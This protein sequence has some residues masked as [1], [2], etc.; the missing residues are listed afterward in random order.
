MVS[1]GSAFTKQLGTSVR[2]DKGRG[3]VGGGRRKT[4]RIARIVQKE[5]R[6]E[7]QL[8]EEEQVWKSQV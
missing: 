7:G 2:I 1:G 4:A 6:I 8:S 3:G 5:K